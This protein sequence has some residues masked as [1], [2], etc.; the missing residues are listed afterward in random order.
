MMTNGLIYGCTLLRTLDPT[1]ASCINSRPETI[2]AAPRIF[3]NQ[4]C[5]KAAEGLCASSY[6]V[7]A[8]LRLVT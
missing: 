4:H 7:Q 3:G 8:L 1:R 5:T 6:V 2:F